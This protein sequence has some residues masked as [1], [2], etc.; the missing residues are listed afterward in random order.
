VSVIIRDASGFPA[1]I[2]SEANSHLAISGDRIARRI[3][4]ASC[5]AGRRTAITV[6]PDGTVVS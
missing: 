2:G 5:K 3:V 1:T 4:E 6:R